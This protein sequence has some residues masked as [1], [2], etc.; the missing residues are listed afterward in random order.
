MPLLAYANRWYS[1]GAA[2]YQA[3]LDTHE[4]LMG[5]H[6]EE[7]GNAVKKNLQNPGEGVTFN[8]AAYEPFEEEEEVVVD[9]NPECP[10]DISE[11]AC[12]EAN[13]DQSRK[14]CS[15]NAENTTE[16]EDMRKYCLV[17]QAKPRFRI[18][19]GKGNHRPANKPARVSRN[20]DQ[21]VT[22]KFRGISQLF[23]Q[24]ASEGASGNGT[25][26]G[27][28]IV[29]PVSSYNG[30][31]FISDNFEQYKVTN[32]EVLMKPSGSALDS[33]SGTQG[34][35]T[36]QNCIYSA[37][38][39]TYVQSFID[40]DTDLNPTFAE[41]LARPSLKV[42]ALAPN[43]WTKVASFTP[44]TLSNPSGGVSPTNT[45]TNHWMSTNNMDAKLFGLRGVA[46]NPC[47]VFDTQDNVMCID[48]RVTLT[49]Q[50]KGPKN[51]PSNSSTQLIPLETNN[52]KPVYSGE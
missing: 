52:P 7:Y 5:H 1:S 48:T 17:G 28:S 25:Q 47:P 44:R 4:I 32:V 23:F 13:Q 31:D 35:I 22:R 21:T 19:R 36:Y 2:Q 10:M 34:A 43:N 16:K 42:R 45:F 40:Y 27:F 15:E 50:M 26:T 12:Q 38:N 11:E 8:S 9:D 49:V 39:Q 3:G 18:T 51:D 37:M 41:C 20:N 29:N 46:S 30:S 24:Q 33:P 6:G 14:S